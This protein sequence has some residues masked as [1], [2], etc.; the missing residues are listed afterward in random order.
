MDSD[1]DSDVDVGVD[2]SYV[3]ELLDR[4]LCY[5]YRNYE[6]ILSASNMKELKM[7]VKDHCETPAD[8]KKVFVVHVQKTKNKNGLL[9]VNCN[10]CT[11]LPSLALIIADDDMITGANFLYSKKVLKKKKFKLSHL[12]KIMKAIETRSISLS[13]SRV[14]I[15]DVLAV[16]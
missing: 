1:S 2:L 16:S 9:M 5:L 14:P 6:P 8:N 10:Q 4:H 12:V 3:D 15:E 11:I 13:K 7:K